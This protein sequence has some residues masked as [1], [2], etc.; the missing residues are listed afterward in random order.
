MV[1]GKASSLAYNG[2]NL[3]HQNRVFADLK[4]VHKTT[5]EKLQKNQA[6]Q[7]ISYHFMLLF[8]VENVILSRYPEEILE[9]HTGICYKDDENTVVKSIFIN[10]TV[11]KKGDDHRIS[12]EA[13]TDLASA[14]N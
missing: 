12:T 4:V 2:V 13:S 9:N 1:T 3:Y 6:L 14:F 8:I 10:L 7:S 11:V 5:V